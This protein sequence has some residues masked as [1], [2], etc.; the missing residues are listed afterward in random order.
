MPS[1]LPFRGDDIVQVQHCPSDQTTAPSE[2]QIN[3]HEKKPITGVSSVT[4]HDFGS[5]KTYRKLSFN[6]FDLVELEPKPVDHRKILIDPVHFALC[7]RTF[8]Q[9]RHVLEDTSHQTRTKIDA[10]DASLLMGSVD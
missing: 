7:K 3:Q 10:G 8:S 5:R 2:T 9:A 4:K 6:G 1:L